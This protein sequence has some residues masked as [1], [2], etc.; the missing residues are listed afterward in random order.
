MNRI[1]FVGLCLVGMTIFVFANAD[2][3]IKSQPETKV[4][5]QHYKNIHT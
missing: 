3:P 2:K 1:V 4:I 5:K